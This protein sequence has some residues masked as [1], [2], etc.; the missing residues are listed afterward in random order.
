MKS[1]A[2]GTVWAVA[3]VHTISGS[4]HHAVPGNKPPAREKFRMECPGLSG[5]HATRGCYGMESS[6]KIGC[7][8]PPGCSILC[9]RVG[10]FETCVALLCRRAVCAVVK[11]FCALCLLVTS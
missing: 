2:D 4:G 9:S 1:K 6:S 10:V 11:P 8:V 5:T 7:V 3:N